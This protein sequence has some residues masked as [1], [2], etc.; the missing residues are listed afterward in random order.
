[1]WF[2]GWEGE[3][4]EGLELLY[5]GFEVT[6]VAHYAVYPVTIPMSTLLPL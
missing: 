1:M 4:V 3:T 5:M 2:W 6:L